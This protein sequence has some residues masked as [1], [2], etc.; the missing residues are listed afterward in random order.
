MAAP[1]FIINGKVYDG[2]PDAAI[3]GKMLLK[4]GIHG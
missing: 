1:A 4:M 3:I 2:I